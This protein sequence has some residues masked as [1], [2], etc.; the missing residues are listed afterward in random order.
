MSKYIVLECLFKTSSCLDSGAL[1]V[2]PNPKIMAPN[3]KGKVL[4]YL[5]FPHCRDVLWGPF[6]WLLWW[7]TYICLI[8]YLT[9]RC[10]K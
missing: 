6:L 1:E 2:P 8:G 3:T 5:F 10:I 9:V 4:F 7:L